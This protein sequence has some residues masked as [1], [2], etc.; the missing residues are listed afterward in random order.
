M[1]PGR[2]LLLALLLFMVLGLIAIAI[3]ALAVAVAGHGGLPLGG[4]RVALLRVE[5][6]ITDTTHLVELARKYREDPRI[7]AIVV[8]VESGGGA[9]GASQELF[10]EL[11]RAD[12]EKPVLVSLG[13]TAAS[14]GYYVALG[15]RRIFANPGTL[16]GSIGVL[17]THVD[18][19]GLLSERL[20]LRIE[21]VVSGENKDLATPWQ[22]LSPEDRALIETLIRD[23]HEQFVAAVRERRGEALRRAIAG[24]S[25]EGAS[26]EPASVTEAELDTHLTRLCDGRPFT[27]AQAVA[28]GF[29]DSLGTLQDTIDA[30]AAAAGIEG[31]PTVVEWRPRGGLLG[32]FIQSFAEDLTAAL[33]DQL[34]TAAPLRYEM[35]LRR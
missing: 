24:L 28:W 21:D 1:S 30:A 2:R 14:G 6:T 12:S 20:G 26:R 33:R 5:G 4:D 17:L 22:A 16:T 19:S 23:V 8:R 15:G 29:V 9:V 11:R 13:N 7:R 27:G 35:A 25:A 3:I 31:K 34:T 10:E 32:P 18:L